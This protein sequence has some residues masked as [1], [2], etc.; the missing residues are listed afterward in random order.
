MILA[1]LIVAA[2]SAVSGSTRAT[3]PL[4]PS[5]RYA[6]ADL[7]ERCVD[8]SGVRIG[9]DE[10]RHDAVGCRVSELAEFGAVGDTVLYHAL[11]CLT[12]HRDARDSDACE[13]HRARGIAIFTGDRGADSVALLL[14]RAE[15]E[16]GILSYDAPVIV[17]NPLGTFLQVSIHVAGTGA[18]NE[19]DY[20]V[21]EGGA[22]H[23]VESR[24]WAK[25]LKLPKGVQVWKGVWPDLA[26]MTARL[27]L[28]RKGDANCCP[29]GG[30]AVVKLGLVDRALVATSTRIEPHRKAAA[31]GKR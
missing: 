15:P 9:P 17:R 19:S 30:T 4:E 2:V 23:P 14:E 13:R 22:W 18:G 12:P 5:G 26:T 28:Y 27:G 31:A 7:R 20:Y 11:Y 29:T 3:A 1:L 10:S 21:L 6:L 8:L 25:G 24:A 16:I